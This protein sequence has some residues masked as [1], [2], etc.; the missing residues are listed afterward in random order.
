M[1]RWRVFTSAPHRMFFF[2]GILQ[3]CLA[4]LWWL[5][6]LGGRYANLYA[7]L[8]W[9]LPPMDIHAFLMLFAIFPFFI[10]GFLMTTYPRWMNG[11][12][13][14]RTSTVR[15][16]LLMLAGMAC[17]YAAL[18]GNPFG[19]MLSA[20]LFLSGW[21]VGLAALLR[22][23]LESIH[24]DKRHARITSVVLSLG[25]LLALCWYLG[26][27]IHLEVLVSLARVLG[28][29]LL[30]FPVFFAVS[31]R[32][33]PFFS[34]V[35]IRD[36][37]VVRPMS[38]LAIAPLCGC[39]HG[40][41]ELSG[42]PQWTWVAD[43][44][45]A[46]LGF[47]LTWAWRFRASFIAP[48]LAMLH[49]GF[50]WLGVAAL[51]YGVQSLAALSGVAV[52]GRAPLHALTAG[53]FSGMV[54]AMVTRVTLG[55]SGR[56]LVVDRLTWTLFLVFQGVALLRMGADWPGLPWGA[57][58]WV[59]LVAGML[60]LAVFGVWAWRFAPMYWRPRSDGR[61]G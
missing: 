7:P 26:E 41:L 24:P 46:G 22:V 11:R 43:L 61:P 15:A 54:L 56:N 44:P 60:W 37:E 29:W 17:F 42:L 20:V 57:R 19:L 6:D 50:A 21:A 31:H 27:L 45:L 23:Y 8:D 4:M 49:V 40:V 59:L 5:A 3:S 53:Y 34:G 58:A 2:G 52:L 38:A 10:F 48:I 1:N 39:V 18:L 47:Y 25:W 51:L 30:L 32:M 12:E 16:F 28:V 33:I 35:V 13:V 55:H 9:S 14:P 36:Y